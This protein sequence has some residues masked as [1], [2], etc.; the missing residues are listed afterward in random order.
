[1]IRLFMDCLIGLTPPAA[2]I[3]ARRLAN[4]EV[5]CDDSATATVLPPRETYRLTAGSRRLF[6]GDGREPLFFLVLLVT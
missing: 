1:M 2:C 4:T 6:S 5:W 3:G